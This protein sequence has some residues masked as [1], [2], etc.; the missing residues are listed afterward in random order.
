MLLN[1]YVIDREIS[2]LDILLF[3]FAAQCISGRKAIDPLSLKR[4]FYICDHFKPAQLVCPH[5]QLRVYI[6]LLQNVQ[7]QSVMLVSSID[8]WCEH[9][10]ESDLVVMLWG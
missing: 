5:S 6:I 2:L 7:D 1:K 9:R 8:N 4:T 3:H 10:Y